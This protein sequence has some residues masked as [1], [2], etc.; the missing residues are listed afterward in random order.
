[1]RKFKLLSFGVVV[2]IL[3]A[4][5]APTVAENQKEYRTWNR[6]VSGL[7][8]YP[9]WLFV[10]PKHQEFSSYSSNWNIQGEFPT[11]NE[12]EDWDPK[13]WPKQW[14]SNSVMIRLF[15]G[16]IFK[17]HYLKDG[18]LPVLVLGPNFYKLSDMDRRRSLKLFADQSGV[19]K[20]GYNIIEL[21]DWG[22]NKIVGSYTKDGMF[23]Y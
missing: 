10:Q 23:L 5:S 20:K 2:A 9:E 14:N 6:T 4:H 18:Q 12:N 1:M 19:L 15:N 16:G 11:A 7:Q 3:L 22:D 13:K 8:I 21:V 17:T